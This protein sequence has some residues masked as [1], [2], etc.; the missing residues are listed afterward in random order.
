MSQRIEMA[1]IVVRD[2]RVALWRRADSAGWDLPGGPLPDG[3]DDVDAAMDEILQA[4]GVQAPAVEEDFLQTV[5]LKR[6]DGPVVLNLYGP[7]E[8]TGEP[9][10]PEGTEL[11][12][13]ALSEL[14]GVAMDDGLREALLEV[15]GLTTSA[16]T[17]E[18]E[19]IQAI[20]TQLGL[21]PQAPRARTVDE[22]RAMG[23]D[24]LGTLNAQD[25]EKAA[26]G[27]YKMYGALTD[28]VLEFALGSVWGES[29]VDRRTMS[30]QVVAII[31]TQGQ[32]GPLR[33]HINGA[34]NHGATPEQ[35]VQTM[36]LVAAY[37]GFPVALEAW[38]V[39]EKVLASHGV[40][41]NEVGRR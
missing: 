10:A 34:L 29:P 5:Y 30:L 1:A 33:S 13:V 16:S 4:N 12:W 6:P 31:A 25:G 22:R 8:W 15:L 23:L 24:V 7:T 2:G 14:P 41:A 37:A 19:L 9:A 27:M 20:G 26:A 40:D 32:T 3:H 11:A 36:R 17:G 28:D 39:L 38:R 21:A 18:A 35:L